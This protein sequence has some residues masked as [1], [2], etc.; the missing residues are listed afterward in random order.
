MERSYLFLINKLSYLLCSY[1]EIDPTTRRSK[2]S[3]VHGGS[4]SVEET[5]KEH[6]KNK[7]GGAGKWCN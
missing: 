4:P 3:R 2:S 1:I 5:K 6:V 7:A